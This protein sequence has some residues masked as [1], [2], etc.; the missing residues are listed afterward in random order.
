M[1]F[2]LPPDVFC[3][4]RSDD[5]RRAD[6]G[7]LYLQQ[8]I[9]SCPYKISSMLADVCEAICVISVFCGPQKTFVSIRVHSWF[10]INVLIMAEAVGN[11]PVA[12]RVSFHSTDGRHSATAP[13]RSIRSNRRSLRKSVLAYD[14][15]SRSLFPATPPASAPLSQ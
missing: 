3:I 4:S 11:G 9:M 5:N 12:T 8:S 1:I 14:Q 7:H 10:F 6:G 15:A 2:E 13:D